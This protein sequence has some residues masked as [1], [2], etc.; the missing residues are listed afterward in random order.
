MTL[1]GRRSGGGDS[2]R[3]YCDGV[4]DRHILCSFLFFRKICKIYLNAGGKSGT[5]DN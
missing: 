2:S 3:C 5:A 4:Q 1:D